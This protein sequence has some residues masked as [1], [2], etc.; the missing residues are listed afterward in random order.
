MAADVLF[1]ISIHGA[2]RELCNSEHL[3]KLNICIN[4]EKYHIMQSI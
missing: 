3:I 1:N 4:L 2:N